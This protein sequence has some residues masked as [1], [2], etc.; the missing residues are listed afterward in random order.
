MNEKENCEKMLRESFVNLERAQ[1]AVETAKDQIHYYQLKL[2]AIAVQ[3]MIEG[4]TLNRF[5]SS[6]L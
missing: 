2:G 3:E 5:T 4:G 1:I 6:E